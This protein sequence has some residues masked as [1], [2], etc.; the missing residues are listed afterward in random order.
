MILGKLGFLG[1]F[2]KIILV[3]GPKIKIQCLW[4][5]SD[6]LRRFFLNPVDFS[7]LVCVVRIK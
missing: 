7:R 1:Y 6:F 3:N 2:P 5:D 4:K